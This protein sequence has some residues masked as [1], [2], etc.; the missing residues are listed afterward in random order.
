M[1]IKPR[2]VLATAAGIVSLLVTSASATA[3][4]VAHTQS[5]PRVAPPATTSS[6]LLGAPITATRIGSG[7]AAGN[8]I[9]CTPN[10]QYPHASSHVLGTVNVVTTV[11]CT[12]PVYDIGLDVA[13]YR[14][15]ALVKDAGYKDFYANANAQNNAAEPC[16]NALYGSWTGLVVTFP[17]GYSPHTGSYYGF[18]PSKQITC[19]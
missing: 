16:H 4:P 8:L 19:P 17:P 15:G 3:E 18:G 5:A 12:E 9:T 7:K 13:L 1:T 14:N 2:Y 11:S 6:A 10:Q